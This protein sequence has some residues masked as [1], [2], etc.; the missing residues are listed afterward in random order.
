MPSGLPFPPCNYDDACAMIL[1]TPHLLSPCSGALQPP[2]PC[3]CLVFT[4]QIFAVVSPLFI[5]FSHMSARAICHRRHRHM[6]TVALTCGFCPQLACVG[7]FVAP[8][9]LLTSAPPCQ[10]LVRRCHRYR[11]VSM[12]SEATRVTARGT[13]AAGFCASV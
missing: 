11:V 4:T 8:L 6:F 10:T 3:M 2:Q 13:C 1:P 7:P 9:P 5:A 12:P